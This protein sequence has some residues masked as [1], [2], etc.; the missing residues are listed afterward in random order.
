MKNNKDLIFI[1][2]HCPTPKQEELLE[3]CVNSVV[4]TGHHLAIISHT[5]IPFHLQKK[6]NYYVY[7]YL[8]DV[9][10]DRE[11]LI[12]LNYKFR[13]KCIRSNLFQKY[14]YGFAIYRMFSIAS[15]IATSFG[16]ENIHHI[17]YD[18]EILDPKIIEE[19]NG[20]LEKFSSVIYTETGDHTGFLFGSFKSFKVKDLPDLFVNYDRQKIENGMK[21]LG[22]GVS[23]D[24]ENFTKNIFTQKGNVLFRD[25]NKLIPGKFKKG[26]MTAINPIP[27]RNGHYTFYYDPPKNSLNIFYKNISES[28]ERLLIVINKSK[29]VTGEMDVGYWNIFELGNFDDIFHVRI[30]NS[31]KILYE[32]EF[33]VHSREFLKKTSFITDE[34]NN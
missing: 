16:Y 13:G 7:D 21:T 5:H 8:N 20:F 3:K 14:F 29:I 30:D 28:K 15:K 9:S 25:I 12:T 22:D 11:L 18:C 27:E 32:I 6:C 19:H 23:K 34:K 24:L 26:S 10:D 33:D 2:A 31:K 1:T 4:N 17:E